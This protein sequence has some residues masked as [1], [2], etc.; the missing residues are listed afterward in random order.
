MAKIK[1][2]C[3]FCWKIYDADTRNLKRGWWLCCSKS[4]AAKKRERNKS[5]YNW[6]KVE[7]NNIKRENWKS[8][9]KEHLTWNNNI[10]LYEDPDEHFCTQSDDF[11][12]ERIY[13]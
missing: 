5:W 4:C 10:Y 7:R 6:K 11:E 12:F 8:Y 13:D 3:D 9:S 1:R 2:R